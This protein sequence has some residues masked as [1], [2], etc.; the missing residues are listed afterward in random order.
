MRHIRCVYEAY[1][2]CVYEAYTVCF[3]AGKAPQVRSY[4]AY[5]YVVLNNPA[6]V[7]VYGHGQPC[8]VLDNPVCSWITLY[9]PG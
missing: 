8:M 9:G 4:V 2:R 7:H 3:L 1:I 6:R 5:K